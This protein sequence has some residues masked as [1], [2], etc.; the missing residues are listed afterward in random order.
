MSK[1]STELI[2]VVFADLMGSTGLF[3]STGNA[4]AARAVTRLTDW[5][6]SVFVEHSGRVVKTLGDGVLAT[7]ARNAD[8]IDA[9][10]S[11][12]RKHQAHLEGREADMK[13]PIRVGVACGA[14]EIVAGDCFGDAVNV[15]ARLSD[16]S[17]RSQIWAASQVLTKM[18]PSPGVRFRDLGPVPIRGRQE[19]CPVHQVEWR[20]DE[21]SDFLTMQADFDTLMP[22][23][24]NDALGASIELVSLDQT[25]TFKSFELPVHIGRSSQAE[26]IVNDQRV[27]R[28][29]ARI[30][31]RNGALLLV[32]VSSYGTW[33]RFESAT[34]DL[35]L[36]REEIVLHG[37]GEIAMGATFA[38]LSAPTVRFRVF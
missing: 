3:E 28:E 34:T 26:F 21:G 19:P 13:M 10:V 35:H 6:G 15:A 18:E 16:L 5:I 38:D 17:G 20:S 29:H 4:R 31:W 23:S 1:Q 25:M 9:V 14:V 8:A 37:S 24:Q 22:Q 36:R 30:E 11:M 2:T 12:Q 32:D 7:F 33:V 27:S